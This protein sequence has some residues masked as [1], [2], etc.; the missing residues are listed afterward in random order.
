MFN[1]MH[2]VASQ[3]ALKWCRQG[4][5]VR[6]DISEDFTRLTLDTV[7][8]CSMGFR[9][10]S[11]YSQT[12]HPFIQAMAEVLTEAGKKTQRPFHKIFYRSADKKF[13]AN[14]N[15]LRSTARQVLDS[16]KINKD[17]A[18]PRKDL[19][20]AMLSGVDPKTGKTMSDE[21]IIDNLITFLVAGHETT[22]GTLSF[23]MYNLLKNP[24]TYRKAQKEVDEVIG[25]GAIKLEHIPKLKYINAVS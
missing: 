4:S 2:E 15:L 22:A 25:T 11:Y 14:T 8:L 20:S 21:S 10:N 19:L 12:L 17:N 24:E 7:A 16:R 3:L 9:F 5:G 18:R 13:R 23:M 1:E 6:L